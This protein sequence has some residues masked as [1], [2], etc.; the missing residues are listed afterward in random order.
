MSDDWLAHLEQ[1]VHEATETIGTLRSRN[2]ELAERIESLEEELALARSGDGEASDGAGE[3]A[4][5]AWQEERQ[6]I[7]RRVE[8]LT[9]KLE[10]L[11]EEG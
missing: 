9:S 6:E 2:Q 10:G 11:L 4:T 8:S 5:A 1:T 3:D 7:R